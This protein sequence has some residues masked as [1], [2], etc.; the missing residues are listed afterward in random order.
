MEGT[1]LVLTGYFIYLPLVLALT[2][3][4]SKTLFK[5]GERF[6]LDIFHGQEEIAVATNKLFEVGFYL[7]N[8]GFALYTLKMYRIISVQSLV[9]NLSTKIGGFAIYLGVVLFF[10][11]YLFMRG[12]KHA[13]KNMITA[14]V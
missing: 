10:N 3:Y 4:V 5:S 8:I 12:R 7:L 13:R 11:L 9:E 6:M 14:D 2:Y 1:N